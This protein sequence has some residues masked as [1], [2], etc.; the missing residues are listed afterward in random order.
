MVCKNGKFIYDNDCNKG[1]S[2]YKVDNENLIAE[3]INYKNMIYSKNFI[4]ESIK[5]ETF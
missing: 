4:T 2:Y 5:S 1:Y 3:I